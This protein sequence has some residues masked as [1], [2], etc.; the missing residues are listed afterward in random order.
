MHHEVINMNIYLDMDLMKDNFKKERLICILIYIE[1]FYILFIR[2]YFRY[3]ELQYNLAIKNR[4]LFKVN[5]TL[6]RMYV[7]S[8][9]WSTLTLTTIGETPRPEQDIEYIFVVADFLIG[10]VIVIYSLVSFATL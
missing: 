2:V 4:G 3:K 8:F 6:L 5:A 10:Y 7:Y 1:I 9:Y